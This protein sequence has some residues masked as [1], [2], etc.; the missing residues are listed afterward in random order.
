MG[1]WRAFAFVL[2][3]VFLVGPVT[4]GR[5]PRVSSLLQ[6]HDSLL[7]DA[8]HM[9]VQ[10]D[11][12]GLVGVRMDVPAAKVGG[13]S[14]SA[15]ES[16]LVDAALGMHDAVAC[17]SELEW[18][19]CSRQLDPVLQQVVRVVGNR[20]VDV[21]RVRRDARALVRRARAALAPLRRDL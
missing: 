9:F 20:D 5:D 3:H 14:V 6:Q 4:C 15:R 11:L 17:A 1:F 16:T 12:F 7:S 8:V 18:P 13:A 10:N 2:V 19:D 21:R